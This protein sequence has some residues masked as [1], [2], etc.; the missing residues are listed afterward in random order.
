MSSLPGSR[1]RGVGGKFRLPWPNS[2]RGR[3][4]YVVFAYD[5]SRQLK[6]SKGFPVQKSRNFEIQNSPFIFITLRMN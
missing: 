6:F 2:D 5:L 1:N 4:Y 3:F